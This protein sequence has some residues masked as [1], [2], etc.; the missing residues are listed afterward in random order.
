[1]LC[2]AQ[3]TAP[4]WAA[5]AGGPP[6]PQRVGSL[7]HVV[8]LITLSQSNLPGVYRACAQLEL[9]YKYTFQIDAIVVVAYRQ[10]STGN[11]YI[12]YLM[13]YNLE[14]QTAHLKQ[15]RHQFSTAAKT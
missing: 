15:H 8:P 13:S 10:C 1:M 12:D 3:H 2:H 11:A 5:G 14:Q 4:V 7:Q 6:T 9:Y